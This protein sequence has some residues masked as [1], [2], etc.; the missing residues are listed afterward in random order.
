MPKKEKPKE[1][2]KKWKGKDWY[3]ILMPEM[4]EG[5]QVAEVPTID[6]KNLV[7]K[8]LEISLPELVGQTPKH[9]MNLT[10]KIT[11]VD[12]TNAHTRFHGCSVA[13]EQAYRMVRKRVQKV[14]IVTDMALNDGWKVQLSS[15][16]VLNRNVNTT[17]QTR[18][19]LAM[20]QWLQDFS[21]RNDINGLINAVITGAAQHSMK[22]LVNKIY[23][24]RFNEVTKIEVVKAA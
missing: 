17:V 10:F 19:R 2:E 15:V 6:P 4:F 21:K 22:K 18:T 12:G 5:K 20:D 24:A 7:G 13:R 9:Y 11:K 14:E 8:T 3:A 23:P 1:K 16:T